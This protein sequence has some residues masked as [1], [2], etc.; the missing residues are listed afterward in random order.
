MKTALIALFSIVVLSSGSYFMDGTVLR[1][2]DKDGKNCTTQCTS[3]G[4]CVPIQKKPK[5]DA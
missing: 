4:R 1:G 5:S 2:C 3:N